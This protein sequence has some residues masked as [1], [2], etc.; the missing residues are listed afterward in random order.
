VN[1][2]RPVKTAGALISMV[3]AP[4]TISCGW[5]QAHAPTLLIILNLFQDLSLLA[6]AVDHARRPVKI[7]SVLLALCAR[8][9]CYDKI[10][11]WLLSFY[12]MEK[13]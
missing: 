6:K 7:A 10:F 5:P 3:C 13:K 9:H 1:A 8:Q 2:R 11:F 4:P 12:Q